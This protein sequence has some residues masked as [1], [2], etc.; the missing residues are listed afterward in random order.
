MP[1]IIG[2]PY[3]MPPYNPNPCPYIGRAW[4]IPYIPIRCPYMP[5][6]CP[7][8]PIPEEKKQLCWLLVGLHVLLDYF[9]MSQNWSRLE[10]IWWKISLDKILVPSVF[11]LLSVFLSVSVSVGVHSV[12][13]SFDHITFSM[14][15]RQYLCKVWC[16]KKNI[17][18]IL[19]FFYL[20]SKNCFFLK[21]IFNQKSKD[22]EITIQ[23]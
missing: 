1:A 13:H 9:K 5:N 20:K 17:L 7:Y 14:L 6:P 21:C 4:P 18:K 16:L 2:I 3:P 10:P 19:N 8:M 15:F 11:T 22:A 23:N 12:R